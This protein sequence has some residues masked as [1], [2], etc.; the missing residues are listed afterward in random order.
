MITPQVCGLS[1]AHRYRTSLQVLGGRFLVDH[2]PA[3]QA[4]RYTLAMA[5]GEMLLTA[6]V[7]KVDHA[8]Y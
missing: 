2:L 5:Y 3:L 8:L 4:D 7:F 1:T 6:D